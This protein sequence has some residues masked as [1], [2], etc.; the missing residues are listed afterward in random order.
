[1]L[2]ANQQHGLIPRKLCAQV[3]QPG[4]GLHALGEGIGGTHRD[5][6]TAAHA[7]IG[8]KHGQ[9]PGAG[10]QTDGRR[11]AMLDAQGASGL[12]MAGID[13]AF[14][15]QIGGSQMKE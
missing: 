9:R 14:F 13:A 5:A 11:G 1:M 10:Q 4:F 8:I 7:G 2:R 6:N 12:T 3:H 15:L